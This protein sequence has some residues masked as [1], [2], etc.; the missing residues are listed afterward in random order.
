LSDRIKELQEM[1][2]IVLIAIPRETEA[3]NYYM[4][5]YNRTASETSRRMFLYLAEQEKM[6]EA[7]LKTQ[8]AELKAELELEK[9]KAGK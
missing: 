6:H 5:A 4:N 3:Y 9:L 7:K 2:E 1:I 8:L